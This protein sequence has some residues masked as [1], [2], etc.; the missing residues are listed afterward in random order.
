MVVGLDTLNE[1]GAV[2]AKPGGIVV[3]EGQLITNV[4]L[5][6]VLGIGRM[7]SDESGANETVLEKRWQSD[8]EISSE[9]DGL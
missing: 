4:D 2:K 7:A 9:R 3:V 5:E 8:L 6:S 1:S